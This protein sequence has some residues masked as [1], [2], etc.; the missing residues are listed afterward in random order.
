MVAEAPSILQAPGT[1]TVTLRVNGET[2]TE[3]LEVRKDPHSEGS[4]ADI[5][6]QIAMLEDIQADADSASAMI[7]RIESVRRQVLDTRDIL[8]GRGD[9][10]EIVAA[11]TA[12]NESLIAV[13][14]GLFQMQSTGTG[15]D[16][17]RAPSR[18]MERLGYLFNTTSVADFRPTD[19]QGE[20]HVV[21]KERLRLIAAA[22]E[23]VLD[24]DLEEFNQMLQLGMRIV[25]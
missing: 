2:F 15:Q 13:E 12:L 4:L 1:Y 3:P 11:A 5:Q 20:V 22:V 24:D 16:G 21:L 8:T 10:D 9:Q 7:T 17:I 6:A 18:L 14:Q 19:Q 23:A 25:S